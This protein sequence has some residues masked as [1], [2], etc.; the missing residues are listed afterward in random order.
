MVSAI[1]TKRAKRMQY[2]RIVRLYLP[3]ISRLLTW[4]ETRRLAAQAFKAMRRGGAAGLTK[5]RESLERE[6]KRVPSK[7]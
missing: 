7:P 1:L 3:Q 2:E 6:K 4:A 5:W